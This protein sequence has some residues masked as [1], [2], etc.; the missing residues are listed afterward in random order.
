MPY[1]LNSFYDA[2]K[3]SWNVVNQ[4]LWYNWI[5]LNWIF[6][7][8]DKKENILQFNIFCIIILNYNKK[9]CKYHIYKLWS[10]LIAINNSF[11][12]LI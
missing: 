3:S 11:L 6:D 5:K 7:K 10:I 2:Y 1:T 9:N 8:N 4:F 12:Y